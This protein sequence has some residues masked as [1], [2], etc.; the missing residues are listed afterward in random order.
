LFEKL[1]RET[2]SWQSPPASVKPNGKTRL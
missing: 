1:L 2:D